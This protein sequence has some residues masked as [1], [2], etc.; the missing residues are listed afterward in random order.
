MD[1]DPEAS[2]V[3]IRTFM[4]ESEA[5]IA[6]SALEAFGL[7]CMISRDDSGG[8]RPSLTL[9]QGIRLVVRA[10]DVPRAEEIL[11]SEPDSSA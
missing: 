8:M 5:N 4:S 11:T 1:H 7:E 2:L 3:T 9:V 10:D 6:K